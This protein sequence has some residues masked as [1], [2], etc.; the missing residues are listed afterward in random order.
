VDLLDIV[1]FLVSICEIRGIQDKLAKSDLESGQYSS[2]EIKQLE[3][4]TVSEAIGKLPIS[5]IQF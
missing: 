4:Y 2:D 3:K 1:S 5:T